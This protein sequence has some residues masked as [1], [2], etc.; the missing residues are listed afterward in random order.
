MHVIGQIVHSQ[1][2]K[3][4]YYQQ[5]IRG[6]EMISSSL[7]AGSTTSPARLASRKTTMKARPIHAIRSSLVSS[8]ALPGSLAL[9]VLAMTC[10]AAFATQLYW[11]SDA[12]ANSGSATTTASPTPS[13]IT[14]ASASTTTIA[15][16]ASK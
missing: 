5:L 12:T 7:L 3:Y 15:A 1:E 10:P 8:R 16:S 4:P 2:Q 6:V 11:D 9:M 14:T 13:L